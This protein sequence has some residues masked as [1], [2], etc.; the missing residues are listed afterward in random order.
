MIYPQK[1]QAVESLSMLLYK[2]V[3]VH[4]KL[5]E[6]ILENKKSY[7]SDL[8]NLNQSLNADC[9]FLGAK[10]DK[11]ISILVGLVKGK[12]IPQAEYDLFGSPCEKV[13][14]DGVCGYERNVCRLFPN[15]LTLSSLKAE[16]Y[17]GAGIF[18]EQSED[19]GILVAIFEHPKNDIGS[20]LN[21]LSL[22]AKLFTT[23]LQKD[24]FSMRT[25]RNLALVEEIS[26]MTHTGSWEYYPETQKLFWSRE[27]Y[28]IHKLAVESHI[29]T[30][31]WL[32]FFTPPFHALVK[33]QL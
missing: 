9:L 3:R 22:Q 6:V 15:D 24:C 27:A 25:E 1:C 29:S 30:Q 26:R 23:Q 31:Y 8:I 7:E 10:K 16:A 13:L 33:Q 32:G 18:S 28:R 11:A 17:L 4:T 21:I 2:S 12:P 19:K 14:E 20:W 5:S